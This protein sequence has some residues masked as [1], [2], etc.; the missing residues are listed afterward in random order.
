MTPATYQSKNPLVI[1]ETL[2]VLKYK[3]TGCNGDIKKMGVIQIKLF[4]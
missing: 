3:Q 2:A 4:K 1:T